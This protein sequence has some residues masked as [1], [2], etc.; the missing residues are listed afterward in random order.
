MAA[1][2]RDT[3]LGG[4]SADSYAYVEE[5]GSEGGMRASLTEVAARASRLWSSG[6]SGLPPTIK[7]GAGFAAQ[8]GRIIPCANAL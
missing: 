3:S 1:L 7:P 8:L 6:A 2:S 4:A 5:D